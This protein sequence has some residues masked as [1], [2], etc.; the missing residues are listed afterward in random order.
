[1]PAKHEE[2]VFDSLELWHEQ[3]PRTGAENMAV[4][5]LL[6][7]RVGGK[8]ILRI[9]GWSEPT[10]SFGYFLSL[11]D[12]QQAFA[13]SDLSYVRRWTGGGI[14]DHRHDITY[15]LVIPREHY[16]SQARGAESYRVI[17]QSLANALRQMGVDVRLTREAEGD[18]GLACFGNPVA[19]DLTN[20]AGD[21]IAGA[22][23]RRTRYGLL[24]QGSLCVEID[25]N[26]FGK[27]LASRLSSHVTE[28]SPTKNFCK[29][30]AA[31]AVIRY[32]TDAWLRKK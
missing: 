7:E 12:A 5:Q 29:D 8:P 26:K 31:L 28:F 15:T 17:H 16:L 1:M 27:V 19:Y 30:A 23:Q 20:M 21:K 14:V 3:T 9:Y 25:P 22:G 4:D 24:H 2:R 32:G 18:G 13:E 6:M 10:V 11:A